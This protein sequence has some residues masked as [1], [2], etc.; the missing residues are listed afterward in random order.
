MPFNTAPPPLPAT[1]QGFDDSGYM[2]ARQRHCVY[3]RFGDGNGTE[4]AM[5]TA[6]QRLRM[7]TPPGRLTVL[8]SDGMSACSG[9]F[10]YHSG[11]GA[12]AAVIHYDGGGDVGAMFR[13]VLGY[14][15]LNTPL[16]VAGARTYLTTHTEDMTGRGAYNALIASGFPVTGQ[17]RH[18]G[19]AC[20]DANGLVCNQYD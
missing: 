16:G 5:T 15:G 11:G 14:Y 20:M 18:N 6:A 17:Y 3:G 19:A 1:P 12:V 10:L 4:H 7:L 8:A 2:T 13:K 9:V